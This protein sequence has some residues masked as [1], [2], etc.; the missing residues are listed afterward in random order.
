MPGDVVLGT[1][2]GVLFIPPHL[3]EECC[4]K[5]EKTNLRDRFGLQRLSEGI[6]TTAQIDFTWTDAIWTDFHDWRKT[7]TPPEYAGLDWSAEEEEVKKR[8]EG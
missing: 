3:A 6:Y 5:A 4:I 1:Q 7:N 2:A 8:A